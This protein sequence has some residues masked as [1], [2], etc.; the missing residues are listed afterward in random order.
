[1]N[2][3]D[4]NGAA[5]A[6]AARELVG[7]AFRLHGR[8]PRIGLDCLGVAAASLPGERARHL[9]GGYR[10]RSLVTPDTDTLA[11]RLGL[12]SV[13]GEP[14]PGDVL[15]LRPG[16]CQHH[17][18]VALDRVRIVHAHAGLRRVVLGPLPSDW[19][20]LGHWRAIPEEE[21]E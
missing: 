6:A 16:P 5:I 19:P 7:V 10:L 21:K 14:E 4:M 12:A 18:A 9:P 3:F 1:M 13:C 2:A 15:L 8:D 20:R 17:F 11:E